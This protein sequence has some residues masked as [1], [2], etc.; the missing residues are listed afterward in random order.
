MIDIVFPYN[1]REEFK[2]NQA[3]ADRITKMKRA[4]SYG[5]ASH[6]SYSFPGGVL[7]GRA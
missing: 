2:K 6:T 1:A 3:A 4:V 5:P 7:G